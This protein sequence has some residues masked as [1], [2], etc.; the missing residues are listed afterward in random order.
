MALDGEIGH[1]DDFIIQMSMGQF[2]TL[3]VA[4]KNWWPEKVLI[5][6]KW[7]ENVSWKR[8]KSKRYLR[9]S[10]RAEYNDQSLLTRDYEQAST[11]T[12]I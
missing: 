11:G 5:S 12:T 3:F 1:V 10:R 8:R 4:T 9:L 6:P 2:V 7:I